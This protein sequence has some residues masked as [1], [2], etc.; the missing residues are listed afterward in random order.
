MKMHRVFIFASAV[1]LLVLG[2][3]HPAGAQNYPS[4]PIKIIVAATPG[5]PSDIPARLASQILQ[6]KLGQPVVIENRGGGGG[7]I[8]VREVIRSAPNGYTLLST[9]GAQLAVIPALSASAGYD[10]TKDLTPVAKFMDSFQIL[11][12]HSSSPWK[13]IK[14]LIADAKANPGK[15][16]FAHVGN[17]HL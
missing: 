6:P 4:Q 5:G 16:N 3:S 7:V 1:P 2:L 10:P 17:G 12:V 9:G 8:G 13:S 15:F 14:D 11:A